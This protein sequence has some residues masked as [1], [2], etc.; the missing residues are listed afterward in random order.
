MLLLHMGHI[1]GSGMVSGNTGGKS[2]FLIFPIMLYF[3]GADIFRNSISLRS[4][5]VAI[6][7]SMKKA[8][9]K[10]D[11]FLSVSFLFLPFA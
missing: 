10:R 11:K 7:F 3:Y 8:F 6:S 2:F 1:I 9:D 5:Q 4:R